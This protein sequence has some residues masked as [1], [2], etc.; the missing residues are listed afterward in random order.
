M[1]TL[2]VTSKHFFTYTDKHTVPDR[3][4]V[5]VYRSNPLQQKLDHFQKWIA[6]LFGAAKLFS[7]ISLKM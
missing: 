7:D 6:G 4:C 5:D 2:I 3:L 1:V